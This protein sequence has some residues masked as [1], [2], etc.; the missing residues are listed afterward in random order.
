M[1]ATQAYLMVP[2]WE[3]RRL[4]HVFGTRHAPPLA[5]PWEVPAVT[6]KQEHGD[7]VIV[8]PAPSPEPSPL[9][10][11]GGV[12]IGDTLITDQPGCAVGVFTA[13]CLP[14]LL[15]DPQRGAVAAVHAGWRGS[16]LR[17]A[18]KAVA[19]MTTTFGSLPSQILAALGPAIGRCCYEVG[20]QVLEPLRREFPYWR[21][22]VDAVGDPAGWRIPV[23]AVRIPTRSAGTRADAKKR[24]LDL[25]AWN[26]R[27][28]EEAGVRQIEDLPLCTA[29][30]PDL[31]YS[32]RRDGLSGL[33]GRGM[34]SGI[35]AGPP[36]G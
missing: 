21:D 36:T 34:L 12:R 1:G 2:S 6:A 13:D 30:R 28:L 18:Q 10:G 11:E 16:L 26:R 24:N 19:A 20:P 8:V 17:I 33:M 7:H 25:R 3:A 32:Y 31:F 29:C 27:Q 15:A 14:I 9:K 23:G 4:R 5:S 35:M 22:L